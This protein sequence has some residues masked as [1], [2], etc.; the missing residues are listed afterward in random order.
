MKQVHITCR[1]HGGVFKVPARRGRRPVKCGGTNGKGEQIPTCTRHGETAPT[2]DSRPVLKDTKRDLRAS[3][4]R[5]APVETTINVSLPLAMKAKEMLTAKG[6]NVVGSAWIGESQGDTAKLEATRDDEHL[7]MVW[8]DGE[9]T[10]QEYRLW[11][12]SH[13]AQTN[14]RPKRNLGF[15]PDEMP[16]NELIRILSG[17]K[18]TWYNR[19]GTNL[20][21]GTIGNKVQ[22][23]HTYLGGTGDSNPGERV[24]TFVD[25]DGNGF[26]S[27]HVS[28][29]MQVG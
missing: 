21:S 10:T 8:V 23:S 27:F 7:L 6:W 15:D 17:Q 24:I 19:L 22:I 11:K 14:G 18:V 5:E 16:D 20:E 29:L 1:A 12:D 26:R 25:R 13:P 3:V 9:L 4:V 2:A 28:A